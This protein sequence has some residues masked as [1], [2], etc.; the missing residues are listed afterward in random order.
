MSALLNIGSGDAGVNLSG[1]WEK[2]KD[3]FLS[4]SL[5]DAFDILFLALTF[6]FIFRIFRGRKG[7]AVLTGIS[8]CIVFWFVSATFN[9]DGVSFIFS[10]VFEIGVIALVIIFQPEIRDVLERIGS[11]TFTGVFAIGDQKKKQQAYYTAVDNICTAV[12][13]LSRTKTGALI[14]LSRTTRLD[15]VIRTGVA[16]NADTNSFLL[17]NLF[18]NKAPLH[19]GAVVIDEGRVVA[20]GCLLPLTRRQDI[21]GDLGTRHRAAVGMSEISDAI[22]I[23][24]SEETGVISVA[25]D[26]TLTRNY[27][28]D[29]LRTLLLKSWLRDKSDSAEGVAASRKNRFKLYLSILSS[30]ICAVLFWLYVTISVDNVKTVSEIIMAIRLIS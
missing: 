29:S 10:K 24:V 11:G 30:V 1:L 18:F 3:A 23:V 27:T 15:D 20:A 12:T 19:D 5:T 14:V 13:D 2:T 21:D 4:F 28:P 22:I 17:R 8:V 9:L 25:S 7:G 16:I 6:F 26:C